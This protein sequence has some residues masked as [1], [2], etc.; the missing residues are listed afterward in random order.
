MKVY[1]LTGGIGSGKS[2]VARLFHGLGIPVVDADVLARDAVAP[3]S[4]GLA[5][6]VATFGDEVLDA[7]GRLDRHALARVVFNDTEKKRRLEAIIHPRVQMAFMSEVQRLG[8]SS[9]D[10]MIY[11]VPILFEKGLEAKFA[12]VVLVCA[13]LEVRMA[14]VVERDGIDPADVRARMRHQLSD[15][16]TRARATYIIEN[17]A[18]LAALERQVEALARDVFG[19]DIQRAPDGTPHG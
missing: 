15:D 1:G 16:E 8:A 14:R 3:G 9:H 19:V 5:E 6:V 12:G 10:A 7:A 4:P 18:D 2:T 13:P 11:E 17:D